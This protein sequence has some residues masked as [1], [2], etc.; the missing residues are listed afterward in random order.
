MAWVSVIGP[1]MEQVEYRLQEGAGCG[2]AQP[3]EHAHEPVANQQIAYRLADE[4]ALM[5]IG[6]G[7]REVGITPQTSLTADQHQ[8]ADERRRPAH[9]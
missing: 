6:E 1:S 5:W 7:L 2:L 9:R 4:R 8:G 3:G